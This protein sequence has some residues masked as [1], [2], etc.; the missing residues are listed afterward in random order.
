VIEKE[1][2]REGGEGKEGRKRRTVCCEFYKLN[3]KAKSSGLNL[4]IA[5][6]SSPKVLAAKFSFFFCNSRIRDSIEFS[7][8][9]RVT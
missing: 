2:S 6:S 5:L 3:K 9:N 1:G 8:I 7:M 4:P